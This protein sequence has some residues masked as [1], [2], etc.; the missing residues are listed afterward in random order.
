MPPRKRTK[1]ST[2]RVTPYVRPVTRARSG[3][4]GASSTPD[5]L[6][7]E[8]GQTA[9]T[10]PATVATAAHG[11]PQPQSAAVTM[12]QS[13]TPVS[14]NQVP[15]QSGVVTMEMFSALQTSMANMAA[16]MANIANLLQQRSLTDLRGEAF[17]SGNNS[18]PQQNQDG[19]AQAAHDRPVQA[20]NPG[21]N[22][23]ALASN[24]SPNNLL[25]GRGIPSERL[26]NV[27]LVSPA[28]RRDILSGKDINLACLLI[29]GYNYHDGERHII[30][31]NEALSLKPL[32][33]GRVNRPL[34]ITEFIQAFTVY[35]NVMCEAF[36]NRRT[37]LDA[38]V[39]DIVGMSKRFSGFAFY[40]YHRDFSAKAAALLLNHGIKL[41]WGVRDSLI[42]TSTFSGLKANLCNICNSA[43]HT[44]EVCPYLET[45]R[46][47]SNPIRFQS[48]PSTVDRSGRRRV[49]YQG[50]EICNN[51]NSQPGCKRSNCGF[52]HVCLV[53]Y[54]SDHSSAQGKCRPKDQANRA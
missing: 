21:V 51:F 15:P 33:D 32:Q 44:T 18:G 3:T 34:T 42:Y 49:T 11:L 8:Q 12:P 23:V 27:E 7:A 4:R 20:T 22:T 19:G 30:I 14:T 40:D 53:C 43:V 25:Q 52:S 39:T 47:H 28:I 24:F 5:L 17:T 16:N 13:E 29:P 35:K 6:A 46:P 41:D 1:K 26:P 38:Y 31:G 54:S 2:P 50:K 10:A 48:P 45:K 36:P 9:P 37:E